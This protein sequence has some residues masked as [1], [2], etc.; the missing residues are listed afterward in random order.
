[1]SVVRNIE[2]ACRKVG[3]SLILASFGGFGRKKPSDYK[4]ELP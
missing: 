1:M 4:A 3:R 2:A